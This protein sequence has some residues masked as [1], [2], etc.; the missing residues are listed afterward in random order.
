M[1]IVSVSAA[2][3][4]LDSFL[5]AW[6][7]RDSNSAEY[8]DHLHPK[9]TQTLF[10]LG[11][12]ADPHRSFVFLCDGPTAPP[13]KEGTTA[14]MV[15]RTTETGDIGNVDAPMEGEPGWQDGTT[16][17]KGQGIGLAA[18]VNAATTSSHSF[19]DTPSNSS[20]SNMWTS[21]YHY[22]NKSDTGAHCC[23]A[24][25]PH[26]YHQEQY[27]CDV[28]VC[29]RGVCMCA[30][31]MVCVFMFERVCTCLDECVLECVSV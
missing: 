12:P 27:P 15:T 24:T 16:E 9:S 29:M 26:T 7:K 31:V 22:S 17:V 14:A 30:C 11:M 19:N 28:C 21:S 25:M 2:G 10:E 23:L 4:V 8:A 13:V 5:L 20:S 1:L 3:Y 6:A 18:S